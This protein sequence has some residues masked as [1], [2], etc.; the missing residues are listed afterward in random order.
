[1]GISEAVDQ[2]FINDFNQRKQSFEDRC[3]A[4]ANSNFYY[5]MGGLLAY[6]SMNVSM[7]KLVLGVPYFAHD[8]ECLV[9]AEN[10]QC[11]VQAKSYRGSKCS[12]NVARMVPMNELFRTYALRGEFWDEHSSTYIYNYVVGRSLMLSRKH[13]SK[14]PL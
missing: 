5:T 12:S 11:F 7:S 14:L 2:L 8:Y 3:L 6:E 10:L 1:M 4:G 13:F 9:Y